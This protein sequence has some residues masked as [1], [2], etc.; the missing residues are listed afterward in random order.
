M[1]EAMHGCMAV[2]FRVSVVAWLCGSVV[3][4]WCGFYGFMVVRFSDSMVYGCMVQW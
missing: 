2:W 1:V 3:Q 4:W